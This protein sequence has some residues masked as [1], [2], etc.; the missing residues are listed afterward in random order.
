LK[1]IDK[2]VMSN[3]ETETR[4]STGSSASSMDIAV[5][6]SIHGGLLVALSENMQE[7]LL[8]LVLQK[9]HAGGLEARSLRQQ[10]PLRKPTKKM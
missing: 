2:D 7:T 5:Y 1:S 8:H 9:Q 3:Q 10:F 6:H 4:I